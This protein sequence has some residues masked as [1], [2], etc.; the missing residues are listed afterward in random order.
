MAKV[1]NSAI[2][3][4]VFSGRK[5]FKSNHIK[6]HYNPPIVYNNLNSSYYSL[7]LKSTQYGVFSYDHF[8]MFTKFINKFKFLKKK[9]YLKVRPYLNS[10]KKPAEV[11]MGK[12]KGKF[13]K[14]L[15]PLSPGTEILEIRI[16]RA[17][18]VNLED[19]SK[20][21]KI[22][23]KDSTPALHKFSRKLP[24]KTVVIFNDL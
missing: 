13:N 9:T 14:K 2:T 16:S 4:Y 6:V 21:K 18:A 22:F 17:D 20:I 7:K 1:A 24:V 8:I 11:R 5:D 15:A 19:W 23:L 3:S 10:T 12:G